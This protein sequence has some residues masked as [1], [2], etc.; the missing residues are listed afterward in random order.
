MDN[1]INYDEALLKAIHQNS[2]AGVSKVIS[3]IPEISPPSIGGMSYLHLA[4]E[5]GDE[6]LVQVLLQ[7]TKIRDDRDA[8]DQTSSTPLILAV[9][10]GSLP[11]VEVLLRHGVDVNRHDE[12]TAGNTALRVAVEQCDPLLVKVLLDA[13]AKPS[14]AGWMGMNAIDVAE[15]Q[16]KRDLSSRNKEIVSLLKRR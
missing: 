1:S 6:K 11:I 5:F 2:P 9:K 15:K 13:G 7:G 12:A 8:F 16:F 4:V 10:K 3:E 14:I